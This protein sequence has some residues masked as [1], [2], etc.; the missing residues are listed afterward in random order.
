MIVNGIDNDEPQ[1]VISTASLAVTEGSAVTF[2]VRLATAPAAH[3]TVTS[4]RTAGDTDVTVTGGGSLVFTPANFAPA[5][6]VQISA[7]QNAD[8][9]GD[10]AGSPSPLRAKYPVRSPSRSPTTIRSYPHSP[11][12]RCSPG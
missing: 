3:V 10:E 1:F 2:T 5:Q 9:T 12:P 6:T 7:A 11:A 8:N 4:A